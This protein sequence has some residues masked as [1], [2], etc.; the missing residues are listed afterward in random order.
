MQTSECKLTSLLFYSFF[1]ASLPKVGGV[2]QVHP[3]AGSVQAGLNTGGAD[4][5]A[6]DSIFLEY[7]HMRMHL[8]DTDSLW[9][10]Q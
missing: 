1:S 2:G 10:S 5:P 4:S 3:S 9:R 7:F 8:R 6:P